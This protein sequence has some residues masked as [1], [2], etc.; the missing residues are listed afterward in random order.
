MANA[1]LPS[2]SW[3]G[4]RFALTCY[5]FRFALAL[6]FSF[7]IQVAEDEAKHFSLL[8]KRLEVGQC[9]RFVET[10]IADLRLYEIRSWDRTLE[11]TQVRTIL[12]SSSA[13]D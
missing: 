12:L 2:S 7:L 10:A 3:I 11:P 5:L 8:S 9:E 1:Y 4:R 6:T 13:V